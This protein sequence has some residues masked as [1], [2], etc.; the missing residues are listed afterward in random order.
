MS[1]NAF[2]ILLD[3][4]SRRYFAGQYITGKII[5]NHNTEVKT[6]GIAL[7]FSG[8]AAVAWLESS[9]E[10]SGDSLRSVVKHHENKETYMD[11][12]LYAFGRGN[13]IVCVL[14]AFPSEQTYQRVVLLKLKYISI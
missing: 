9:E 8:T 2:Y 12:E 13:Y 1:L 6:R 5:I 10:G 7:R 4:P 3:N 11:E 14:A